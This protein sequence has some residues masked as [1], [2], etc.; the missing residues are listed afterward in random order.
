MWADVQRFRGGLIRVFKDDAKYGDP[1]TYA[2]TF[3]EIEDG[4][5]EVVGVHGL[6]PTLSEGKAMLKA[7][8]EAG[9]TVM[10]NRRSGANPGMREIRTDISK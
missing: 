1:Y 10:K 4:L 9:L 3:K 2:F 8:K 6:P 5:V 7:A